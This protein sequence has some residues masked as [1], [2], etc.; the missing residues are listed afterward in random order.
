MI[1]FL[2]FFLLL[3]TLCILFLLGNFILLLLRLERMCT[4]E[5]SYVE[6]R[7]PSLYDMHLIQ[8][9]VVVVFPLHVRHDTKDIAKIKARNCDIFTWLVG[10]DQ[11]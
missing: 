3:E 1:S 4:Y 11:I 6:K 10:D 7:R 9:V 5:S 8:K 2:S